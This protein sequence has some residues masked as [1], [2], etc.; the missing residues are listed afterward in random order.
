MKKLIALAA[1]ALPLGALAAPLTPQQALSRAIGDAPARLRAKSADY[2]LLESRDADGVKT[3]Y[4]F[5][6][7]GTPGFIVA[8]A[9][10]AV[11]PLLGVSTENFL[12]ENGK[13]APAC[14]YWLGEMSRRIA[15][16]VSNPASPPRTASAA[17]G[18]PAYRAALQD[19]LEPVMAIQQP[20]PD[21][22]RPTVS[23]RL[24]GHRHVAGHEIP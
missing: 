20:V 18:P 6:Q 15:Y 5:T 17:S 19:Q 24:R 22:Q 1:L 21:T 16:V 11:A 7:P 12:D 2:R 13:C 9:E 10:D 3:L 8:S 4:I 23:D 14:E